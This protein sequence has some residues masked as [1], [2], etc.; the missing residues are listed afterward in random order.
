MGTATFD[1]FLTEVRPKV[2][3]CDLTTMYNALRLALQ[4][5]CER[6][7]IWRQDLAAIDIAANTGS[8]F[9][10]DPSNAL[11]VQ[12]IYVSY[13][14]N[15]IYPTSTERLDQLLPDWRQGV[16]GDPQWYVS[17]APNQVLFDR[18]PESA[19]TGGLWAN[20]ALKPSSAATVVDDTLYRSWRE[21]VASGA[22]ARLLAIPDKPW[23]NGNLARY[24]AAKFEAGVANATARANNSNT[25]APLFARMRGW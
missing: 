20:V 14:G 3:G 21:P 13:N 19:I 18:V 5:F 22:L 8:Y 7:T 10:T 12:S 4:D 1:S 16:A 24:H 6:S 25:G 2:P 9:L 11:I 15:R 17:P 23:A